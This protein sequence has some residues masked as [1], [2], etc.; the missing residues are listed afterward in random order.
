MLLPISSSR[1]VMIAE[2]RDRADTP[3]QVAK[4][5]DRRLIDPVR[6]LDDHDGGRCHGTARRSPLWRSRPGR[7]PPLAAGRLAPA[8]AASISA[9]GPCGRGVES[10]SQWPTSTGSDSRSSAGK[11]PN[12]RRLA[13]ACFA[14]YEDHMPTTSSRLPVQSAQLFEVDLPFEQFHRYRLTRHPC[15][16][17]AQ[18]SLWGAYRRRAVIVPKRHCI[19]I[20]SP[21]GNSPL[22]V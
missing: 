15:S 9:S 18:T 21:V 8:S 14:T 1:K 20:L 5:V 11:D 7:P 4:P 19:T 22:L 16:I 12:Q 10:G 17:A 6:I 2:E 13:D 3:P